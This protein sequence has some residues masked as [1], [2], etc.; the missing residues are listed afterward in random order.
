MLNLHINIFAMIFCSFEFSNASSSLLLFFFLNPCLKSK[1][2]YHFY[3]LVNKN[4]ISRKFISYDVWIIKFHCIFIV[5]IVL[6]VVWYLLIVIFMVK[7]C[8]N[9][10]I[11]VSVIV[12]IIQIGVAKDVNELIIY[13]SQSVSNGLKCQSFLSFNPLFHSF[14]PIHMW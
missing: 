13:Q 9:L 1:L 8:P 11:S 10:S 7:H 3:L 6:I 14:L 2:T 5:N 4:V 12:Q